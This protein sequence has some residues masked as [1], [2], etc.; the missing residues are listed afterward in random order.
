MGFNLNIFQNTLT[1]FPSTEEIHITLWS[2][3]P[4]KAPG[5]DG[6]HAQF[7]QHS[8]GTLSRDITKFIQTIFITGRVP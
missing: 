4:Q 5:L 7:F 3:H 8:W 1:A 2:I 6:L